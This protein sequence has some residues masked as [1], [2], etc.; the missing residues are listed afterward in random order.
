MAYG[1]STIWGPWGD[2][3]GKLEDG[4]GLLV[5]EI[6]LAKVDEIRANIPISMQRKPDLFQ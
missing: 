6:D 3:I 5:A 1:H 2:V 4:E